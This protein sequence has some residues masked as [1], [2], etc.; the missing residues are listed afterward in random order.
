VQHV[1]L[2]LWLQMKK[3]LPLARKEVDDVLGG[4]EAWRNVDKTEGERFVTL[5]MRVENGPVSISAD[6]IST[7]RNWQRV[8]QLKGNICQIL[9]P[10]LIHDPG[11][12]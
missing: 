7:D 2:P 9:F 4:D 12:V 3:K 1:F 11:L 5:C 8:C 10:F 6:C